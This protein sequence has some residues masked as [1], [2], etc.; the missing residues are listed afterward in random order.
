MINGR[1]QIGAWSAC[2]YPIG[3]KD[4]CISLKYQKNVS[5]WCFELST[6]DE[7]YDYKGKGKKLLGRGRIFIGYFELGKMRS[8]KLYELQHD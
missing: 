4:N 5:G 3:A 1:P 8:G 6:C 2:F 7:N